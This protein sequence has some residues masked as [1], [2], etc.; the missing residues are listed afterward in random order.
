M[1]NETRD[2]R[3]DFNYRAYKHTASASQFDTFLT[4]PRKWWF[5]K[6]VKMPQI[7]GQRQFEFGDRLHEACERW[8]LAD[9]TGRNADGKPLELWPDG[10]DEGLCA[11]D[12][13]LVRR[14]VEQGIVEGV[15]R[16]TPERRVEAPVAYSG[17]RPQTPRQIVPGVGVCGY[18]DVCA[19]GLVE[20]HKSIKSKTY[21]KSQAALRKDPQMMLYGAIGLIEAAEAGERLDSITLRQNQFIKNPDDLFVR[22]CE[23]DVPAEEVEAFWTDSI[24]PAARDMLTY[25]QQLRDKDRWADVE[26]PR[27]KGACQEYGGCPFARICGLAETPAGYTARIQRANDMPSEATLTIND[28]NATE[29][30]MGIFDRMSKPEPVNA[31]SSPEATAIADRHDEAAASASAATSAEAHRQ[32]DEVLDA[33]AETIELSEIPPWA[34][35]DCSACKG[36]GFNK[37]HKPCAACDRVAQKSGEPRVASFDIGADDE[38]YITW[39][40]TADSVLLGR[41]MLA[42]SK[43]AAGDATKTPKPKKGKGGKRK[44][45]ILEAMSTADDVEPEEAQPEVS[46]ADAPLAA[47]P[48]ADD[49]PATEPEV[50][51]GVHTG[52]TAVVAEPAD[53]NAS[54]KATL[55][56]GRAGRSATGFLL[57]YGAVRRVKME[58]MDLNEVFHRYAKELAAAQGAAS[59]Y[60]LDR[61]KR[62]DQMASKAEEIAATIPSS[63][64]V[65]VRADDPDIRA[66]ASALEPFASNVIE[67]AS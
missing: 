6:I 30:S 19:P 4:C 58:L 50:S 31:G 23:V 9:D 46:E 67:G 3:K 25:K 48:E 60:L 66:F 63:T 52:P 28:T 47:V 43:V 24:E 64:I 34:N 33:S 10:W 14:L 35:A 42:V 11:S 37:K 39:T 45:P 15:L 20:D 49:I 16:R 41:K 44:K 2:Y 17:P 29:A 26:G 22:G 13:A 1:S 54:R 53:L 62:R 56:K 55:G 8:L 18:R 36:L 5:G 59:F 27:K 40:R 32:V 7:E 61:F 38:G 57:V 51:K 65:V 21:M 12:S